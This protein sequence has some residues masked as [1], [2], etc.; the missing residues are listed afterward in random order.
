PMPK[1]QPEKPTFED[2]KRETAM[3][4]VRRLIGLAS[5][6]ALGLEDRP[7]FAQAFEVIGKQYR[8]VSAI[9]ADIGMTSVVYRS[10]DAASKQLY[11]RPF[12]ALKTDAKGK[13]DVRVG[14]SA[15]SEKKQVGLTVLLSPQGK[16]DAMAAYLRAQEKTAPIDP[17]YAN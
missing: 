4:R 8:D 13:L 3:I 2:R 9:L 15:S 11:Y 1:T 10:V 6:L 17:Q 14:Q 7:A 16:L 5:L 12:F